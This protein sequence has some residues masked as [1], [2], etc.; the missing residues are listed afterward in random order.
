MNLKIQFSQMHWGR[1]LLIGVLV[2]I[3]VIILNLVLPVLAN[4]V[5]SQSDQ[6]QI[7]VQVSAWSTYI[8]L[9]LL[10][11]GGAVWVART[12]E[13]EPF[14]H[15]VL[16][17]LFV[18]VVICILTMGF[19]SPVLMALVTLVLIMAAGCIGGLVGNRGL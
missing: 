4:H 7:A 12:V 9:F 6:A 10:T 11:F 5:W 3:L 18:G 17:G 19:G 1:V 8:L 2:V 13:I 16:V 14:L 15:G